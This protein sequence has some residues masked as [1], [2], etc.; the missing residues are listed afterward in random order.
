M[1]DWRWRCCCLSKPSHQTSID[2]GEIFGKAERINDN[3]CVLSERQREKCLI[4]IDPCL[5]DCF[6]SI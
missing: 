6:M 4:V 2:F 5:S 1:M 3:P